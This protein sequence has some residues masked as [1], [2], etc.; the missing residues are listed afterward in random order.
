VVVTGTVVVVMGA[1][2]VVMG[3]VVV[4]TGTVVVVTGTVVVVTGT[5]VV[6][7][8]TVVVVV[9]RTGVLCREAAEDA[10]GM[11]TRV[12]VHST[13][14]AARPLGFLRDTTEPRCGNVPGV[15]SRVM[16]SGNDRSTM[17]PHRHLTH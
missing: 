13:P 17:T 11:R 16:G 8:G 12:S 3:T 2:V 14:T 6:V 10:T 7:T 1:V 15:R 4:V 9:F 5:V